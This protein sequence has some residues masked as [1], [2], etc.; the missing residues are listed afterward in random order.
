MQTLRN[1]DFLKRASEAGIGVDPEYP[2]SGCLTFATRPTHSRF[3]V[4]PNDPAAWPYF[5]GCL[6]A[7]MDDWS[8]VSLW[9]RSG[10]WPKGSG[11]GFSGESIRDAVLR[12]AGVPGD[13]EGALMFGKE[14]C[15]SLTAI[16]FVY[17]IFGWC[18]GD[19]LFI[20]PDHGQQLLQTDHHD[21]VHAR[22]L[23]E[24]RIGEFVKHMASNGYGLPPEPPDETFRWPDWMSPQTSV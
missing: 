6:F 22:C 11:E 4:V 7:G 10:R 2:D 24:D 19:D 17:M 15:A 21:V 5:I 20:I 18:V 23:S 13:W 14:D 16:L 12:G 9:P 1:D 3:W 8:N